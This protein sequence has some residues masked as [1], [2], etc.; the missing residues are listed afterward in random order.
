MGLTSSKCQSAEY[1]EALRFFPG[2]EVKR[3]QETYAKQFKRPTQKTQVEDI[4]ELLYLHKVK[5][6]FLNV[7][8]EFIST[9]D[10]N[11]H[12]SSEEIVVAKYLCKARYGKVIILLSQHLKQLKNSTQTTSGFETRQISSQEFASI[13]K[14][15][16]CE[17]FGFEGGW[18]DG[19]AGSQ[20]RWEEEDLKRV[21]SNELLC[22][23]EI[24]SNLLVNVPPLAD[25]VSIGSIQLPDLT[26]DN[27]GLMSL[28]W[29]WILS[30]LLP[31][32][33][34][35]KWSLLFSSKRNGASFNAFM[36]RV[37]LMGPTIILVREKG[38]QGNLF[39]GYAGEDW[40]KNGKFFGSHSA[41]L[42]RLTP[43][44]SIY[45]ATGYNTN[46]Q[47]CGH[48]FK[49][50]PNGFGFGGQIGYF[51]L[52]VDGQ[53]DKGM[54]RPVAT[55]QNECLSSNQEFEVDIVECWQVQQ[56]SIDDY[57]P[58]KGRSKSILERK[59]EDQNLLELSG[60]KLYTRD[61][62]DEPLDDE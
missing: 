55:F 54:S 50:L 31:P 62:K 57:E 29:A 9:C 43:T 20:E 26:L 15:V 7:I 41:F 42:F 27:G 3:I 53:F 16:V 11:N 49:E 2:E 1:Q 56:P 45:K 51:G 35:S 13:L 22:I 24:V 19:F 48:T 6:P 61:L 34:R 18:I 44:F 12:I 28:E 32:S 59:L 60:K 40:E 52:F 33:Q 21:L 23:K 17:Q 47:W 14:L 38:E 8:F 58:A 4:K 37:A 25:R 39:G 36:G 30:N 10:G 46:F 5:L